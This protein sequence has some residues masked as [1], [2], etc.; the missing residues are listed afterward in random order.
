MRALLILPAFVLAG[1]FVA[2]QQGAP[3]AQNPNPDQL[4]AVL[5]AWEKTLMGLQSFEAKC[6]RTTLDKVF[7]TK[8][9]FEGT[10]KYLKGAGGQGSRASLDLHKQTAQGP[11]PTIFEKYICTGTFLYEYA[12]AEKV[13]RV[14]DLPPPKSGQITDDN[15][16]AFLFGMKAAEA[17]QRYEMRL[18]TGAADL[19]TVTDSDR[20]YYYLQIRPKHPQDKA[21]FTVA[22]LVLRRDNLLPAQLWFHMPNGN[23]ITWDARIQAN[24]NVSPAEFERPNP[25]PGWQF[26]RMSAQAKPKIRSTGP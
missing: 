5:A 25:P 6:Q 23:E 14:H 18:T 10:V 8:E 2:A 7:Q 13:I 9:V 20:F 11:S 16:L 3:P 12:P 21:D 24:I 1:S 15:F 17:K 4:D 19:V 22:R 26:E